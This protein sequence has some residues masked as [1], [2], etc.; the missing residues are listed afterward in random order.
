MVRDR[1]GLKTEERKLS[2]VPNEMLTQLQKS[3]ILYFL[4]FFCFLNMKSRETLRG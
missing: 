2:T 1:K 3:T 4:L